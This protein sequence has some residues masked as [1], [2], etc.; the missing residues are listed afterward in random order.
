MEERAFYRISEVATMLGIG[1]SLAYRLVSEGK[2]PSVY[3]AGCR[4]RRVPAK[5]LRQWIQVQ[6]SSED[7]N[8]ASKD[9]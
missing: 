3:L 4:S 1:K 9:N 5:A 8:E 7:V 2:I 6:E